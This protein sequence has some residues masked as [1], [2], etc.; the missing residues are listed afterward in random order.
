[1]QIMHEKGLLSRAPKGRLHIYRPAQPEAKTQ[2]HLAGDL[3]DRAFGGS[4][5]KLIVAALDSRRSTPQEL[6]EIRR[7]LKQAEEGDR[8]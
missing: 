2:R 5:R 6:A 1:M 8:S 7:L 3:I 4:A